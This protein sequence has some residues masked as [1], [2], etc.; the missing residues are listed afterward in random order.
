MDLLYTQCHTASLPRS[1]F[2]AHATPLVLPASPQFPSVQWK[3]GRNVVCFLRKVW[4]KSKPPFPVS[5]TE[6]PLLSGTPPLLWSQRHLK[7]SPTRPTQKDWNTTYK[8]VLHYTVKYDS[9][10]PPYLKT[11]MLLTHFL[12]SFTR[13]WSIDCGRCRF[14]QVLIREKS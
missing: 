12:G 6:R 11:V 1:A 3:V 7:F 4:G 13:I 2:F 9:F 10:K 8:A 14:G 5:G